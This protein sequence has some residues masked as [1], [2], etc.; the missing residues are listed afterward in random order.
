MKQRLTA[1]S[2]LFKFLCGKTWGMSV[3][4]MLELYRSL[5]LGFLRYSLPVLT[6]TCKTNIRTLQAVQAQALRVCLGLPKCAPTEATISI[7]RDQPIQTHIVVEALRAHIRHFS[8]AHCHHLATLPSERPRASYCATISNYAAHLPSGF[9]PA[10]K[11]AIPPWCFIPPE[12]HLNVPGIRKKSELSSPVLKQ[13]SLILLHEKYADHVHVYTDGSTTLQRSSGAVVVPAKAITVSFKT[14]HPTTSTAAELAALRAALRVVNHE[15][16]QRWSVFSDS[17]A[18]LQS[19][20]SALR[21]GPYEQL[22]FEV[23]YLLHTS[24]EKGHHVKFQW[25]PSHCGVI[26]NEHADNA[27]RSALQGDTLE[28]IPLSRTDA[29]RQL[30]VVAQ[31]ITFST[32]NTASR[33]RNQHHHCPN[34]LRLQTPTGLRRNDATLLCRL[35][36][37]VAFTKSFSFRIEMADNPFC[38]HCGSE[39]TLR[40]I[41]CDCPRYNEQRTSLAAALARIDNR[42]M[43]V[44]TILECRPE[45]SSRVKA[46]KAVLNF[47]KTTDLHRRL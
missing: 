19:L 23:R 39:E 13:L 43:T 37:R 47:L 20:L 8:R 41:F 17:K 10:S 14:D 7:A 27:A 32:W 15:Q 12:V 3:D 28:T 2:Q 36:L 46:T 34:T 33:L 44:E 6:N 21:H 25:L 38:E 18:A 11:P 4:A 45:R 16:P 35:W 26:G 29:A 22:V 30:R 42:Q 5:F 24:I 40:H 9:S 31:K 1:I